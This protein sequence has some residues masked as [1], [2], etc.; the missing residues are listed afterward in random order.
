MKRGIAM[1]LHAILRAKTD[2]MT[3]AGDI[4]LALV[5]DEESG[6]GQGGR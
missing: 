2:G 6:G 5:S 3:S 4:V 1:M